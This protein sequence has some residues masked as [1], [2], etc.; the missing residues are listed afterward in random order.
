M[1]KVIIGN[2]AVSWGVQL[3]RA[4]VISAYPITPQ[5]QVVEELSEM[6][7]SGRLRARFIKVE[8]EHSAM[9]AVIGA[10][11]TGART[12]TATSSQGL[13]LMHEMLHWASGSRLPV[14]MAN[15][16]RALGP[17]WN[18]WTD[19]SDSLSQR[20]TGWVQLYCETNQEVLDTTIMAF[21]LAESLDVP[22]MVVLDAFFLS[23][24][25]EPVDIPDQELVDEFLPKREPT[26]RLDVNDP[27]SFGALVKPDDYMEMRF[28]LQQ[29]MR[30]VLPMYEAIEH[31]W[32][33]I[34]GRR[35]HAVESYHAVDATT[36]LVTSGTITSTARHAIDARRARGEKVGLVKVKMFRPF[37]AELL[38][39][40]L[41]GVERVAVLDRN[42]SP[43]SGGIFAEEL[44]GALYD[45][46]DGERPA[47]HGLVLGLG[48][49]DVTPAT[50]DAIIDHVNAADGTPE[51]PDVW[52][53][54]KQ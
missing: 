15:V 41:R 25:S 46:P 47:V 12:F 18:I 44:R 20:D 1:R 24:T 32:E 21:R 11:A 51:R 19:Q 54:V 7:S 35:Y 53:G 16:N 13:A 34:V 5:T 30:D 28:H 6:C 52:V 17:G 14:V 4:E 38:R 23:H 3:A 48:G 22:V 36:V 45:L 2:H 26:Y 9:A 33:S 10:S 27:R 37:P 43:G 31:E 50:I 42:L 40:A 49:R 29:S 8:S 39:D